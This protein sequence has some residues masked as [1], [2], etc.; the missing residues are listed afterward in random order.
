VT[1]APTTLGEEPV[2]LV[3][4]CPD[5]LIIQTDWFPQPEHA[6]TYNL[7][8]T[9]GVVDADN[10]TYSG[11]L[12][13]TGITLEI[14]AGGPYIGFSPPTSQFYADESIFMAYVDTGTSIRDSGS[15]PVV[16]V[17]AFWEKSP[18][19]LMWDPEAFSFDSFDD[20]G[21]SEAPVLYF[22]GSAYMDFLIGK[23][24]LTADQVD[25]SYDGG[26]SRFVTEQ[27]VQQGFATNEVYRYENDIAEWLKPVDFM[28]IHDAGFEIYDG[29]LS[30]KPASITEDAECL[31]KLIPIVQQSTVDYMNN[32]EPMNVR[33]DEIV[34][35]LNSFWTSSIGLHNAA[36]VSMKEL[37]LVTDGSNGFVGDMDPDRINRLIGEWVPILESL[38]LTSFNPD[39]TAADI[40][41]NE[42]LDETISLGF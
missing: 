29:S 37:G 14:R 17:Y 33:L 30:V 27:V 35:E 5:P 40:S 20:I 41:T 19:I 31:E 3:G 28:L 38:G 12:G 15:L 11:P 18:Q 16:A 32:P 1:A 7:I 9:E 39:V 24:L 25:A 13:D 4:I 8:G 42:F 10:G 6:Y 34:K 2:S 26:P 22:A 21:A 23:G 36:T